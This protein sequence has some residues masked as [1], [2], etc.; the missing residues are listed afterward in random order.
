MRN[1]KLLILSILLSS[2]LFAIKVIDATGR[3]VEV[4]E[5]KKAVALSSTL[6]FLTYLGASEK[7]VA[8]EAIEKRDIDSRPY[9]LATYKKSA[10][11]PVVGEG[12]AGKP[13]DWEKV[14]ALKPDVV[15]TAFIDAA[16]ADAIQKKINTPVVVLSYGQSGFDDAVFAASLRCAASVI[17]KTKRAEELISYMKSLDARLEGYAKT[18]KTK[19]KVYIG[20]VA[21]KG[22]H[23]IGSTEANFFGFKKLG[24]VNISDSTKKSGHLFID[25][26]FI[27]KN[28]PSVIYVD[29]GGYGNVAQEYA[30]EP[31]FFELIPAVYEGRTYMSLPNVFYASNVE[32]MYANAFFY[33]AT[34]FDTKLDV[35]A[36]AGEIFTKFVGIDAYPAMKARY[37]GY[38]R[39]I[40]SGGKII[41]ED[42]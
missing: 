6:R 19:P 25:K 22:Q 20:G 39:L 36:I 8:T 5:V 15:F 21:Y 2:Q 18:A 27:L 13:T 38:S 17:G 30:K 1:I 14:I 32:V 26:E 29:G 23:G 42:Y 24:V 10:L 3:T 4:G 37:G 41:K 12:G 9:T 28:A 34:A 35:G 7:V 16:S 40:F 11:L 31:K 33:A